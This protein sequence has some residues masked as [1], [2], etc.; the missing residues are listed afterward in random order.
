[1]VCQ[2]E[3]LLLAPL[4]YVPWHWE[5][6]MTHDSGNKFCGLYTNTPMFSFVSVKLS[7]CN[8]VEKAGK[9]WSIWTEERLNAK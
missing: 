6:Q 3:A 9:N 2:Q 5:V 4:I 7:L 8:K 1:M